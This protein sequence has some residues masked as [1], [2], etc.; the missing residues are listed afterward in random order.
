LDRG[1]DDVFEGGK[2]RIRPVEPMRRW[3]LQFKGEVEKCSADNGKTEVRL[4]TTLARARGEF[5]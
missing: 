2:I 5:F 4:A 1:G 3:K